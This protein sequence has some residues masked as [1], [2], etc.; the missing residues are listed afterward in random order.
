[1]SY[2]DDKINLDTEA[3]KSFAHNVHL[4]HMDNLKKTDGWDQLRA[5]AIEGEEAEQALTLRESFKLYPTAI[6]WSFAMSL[7]IIMEGYDTA[8]L[9]NI[10]ALETYR[11]KFG[12]FTEG[13][14]WQ[15]TPAW[16]TAVG[17]APTI[18][19]VIGIFIASWFQDKYG[20]RKT[21]MINLVL[22]SAFI[23]VVFFSP[24]IEVL[25]VG[26]LLCGIPWGAFSSSAVSYASEIAP[27]S[28]R[29]YLTT[30]INLCWVI[31]QFISAGVL[32]GV[33]T[34]TDMWSYKIPWAIQ[35]VWP[36]PL[37]ILAWLAPE[38][39]WFFVRQGRLPE[40]EAAVSR[41]QGKH[42]KVTPANT[43]AMMVRTNQF[44]ID[45]ETGSSYIDCLRGVD[46]RRT[47]I[48]CI[49]WAA[50]ILSGS[51]FANMPTYYFQ[52]AGLSEANSFKLGLGTMALAFVG[53]CASWITM[54]KFGRRTVYLGGLS[55]LFVLLMV[56]GG[57]AIP[58]VEKPAAR[59]VQ[60]AF[61]MM[62]VFVYDFTV[63]PMAYCIVGEVSS[64]RLRG[65]TVGLARIVYNI[66]SVVAGILCTYQVN[67][68]AWNWRGLA[69]FFWGGSCFLVLVWAY[70]RLPECKGRTYRQLDILFER[71]ISARKF[72]E[73]VVNETDDE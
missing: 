30:Y 67:P 68:T 66:T 40:A 7:V 28:L 47:E 24:S 18:G 8:L 13:V 31:G 36:V 65:K 35:W 72:K 57:L 64:T 26:E 71:R 46:R 3:G 23:F 20:Y 1:M 70:F 2:S 62:W 37:F 51:S 33:Q 63:G 21:I 10:L 4:E 53:T 44:E 56:I 61:V 17:Q 50:Q 38:S 45:T 41:L 14:G 11:Q 59:W 42:D 34:R 55:T 52:Q 9:G 60:A 32:V 19:N 29:G 73:T 25:F 39:P 15:L 16:Q 12:V 58:A 49:A 6:F 43:V 48:A 22:M 5:D 27:V 54:T 69:G